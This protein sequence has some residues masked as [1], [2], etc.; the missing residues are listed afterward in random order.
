M[1]SISATKTVKQLNILTIH[2][3]PRKIVTDNGPTF[4]SQEFR[5]FIHSNGIS[6]ITSAPYHPSTNGLAKRTVQSFKGSIKCIPSTSI[7]DHLSHFL[8]HYRITPHSTTGLP[9]AV[10]LIGRHL[11]SRFDLLFPDVSQRVK[12]Q[13]QRQKHS[14]DS[15]K[16]ERTFSIG[17]LASLCRELLCSLHCEMAT[18]ESS[19][20]HRTP[21]LFH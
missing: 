17:D 20:S 14:H 21:L 4:I 9:P 13:Q 11:Q 7:Q 3:L 1:N 6:H 12:T 16:P 19:A 18:R 15:T 2:G 10:M 5:D 8:F